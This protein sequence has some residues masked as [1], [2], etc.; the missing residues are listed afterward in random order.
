MNG[1]PGQGYE[2][3]NAKSTPGDERA[4]ARWEAFEAL[5]K[6]RKRY[7]AARDQL[8]ERRRAVTS[9]QCE[10]AAAVTCLQTARDAFGRLQKLHVEDE[11]A[12]SVIADDRP[13]PPAYPAPNTVGGE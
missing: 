7:D 3:S 8:E 6:S 11:A 2:F 4:R 5:E 10:V 1:K 9:A 13:W 12:L